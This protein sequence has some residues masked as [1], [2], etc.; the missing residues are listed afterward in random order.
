MY[1]YVD[2]ACDA[3]EKRFIVNNASDSDNKQSAE[4]TIYVRETLKRNRACSKLLNWNSTLYT[5]LVL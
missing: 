5:S 3:T 4:L 2:N 1:M